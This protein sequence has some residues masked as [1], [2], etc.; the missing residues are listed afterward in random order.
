MNEE[1]DNTIVSLRAEVEKLKSLDVTKTAELEAERRDREQLQQSVATITSQV[2]SLQ[3][4]CSAQVEQIVVLRTD[5]QSQVSLLAEREHTITAFT[6]EL[7]VAERENKHLLQQVSTLTAQ[8][9]SLE[10]QTVANG[11][12]LSH[13]SV[14][15]GNHVVSPKVAGVTYGV[16][17]SVPVELNNEEHVHRK[18]QWEIDPTGDCYVPGCFE[19]KLRM[20]NIFRWVACIDTDIGL[21]SLKGC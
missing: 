5:L 12:V 6:T 8:V 20:V 14:D 19:S 10:I 4:R 15:R 16:V 2:T 9:Q 17:C 13:A 7:D 18:E 1:K 21:L 11:V 3:E